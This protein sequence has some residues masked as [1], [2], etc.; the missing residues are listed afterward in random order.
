MKLKERL[1]GIVAAVATAALALSVAPV[2]AMAANLG[3]GT[4]TVKGLDED[5]TKVELYK[6]ATIT[7]TNDDN[8]LEV[9][10]VDGYDFDIEEYEADPEGV[11]NQI[12]AAVTGE[13]DYSTP[14][15]WTLSGDQVVFE[16]VVPG[17]Y[18]VKISTYN[19][20]T[21]Y[22]PVIMKVA[23]VA[24]DETGEWGNVSGECEPKKDQSFVASSLKK[25]VKDANGDWQDDYTNTLSDAD[26]A[27][28]KIVAP[29]PEYVGLDSDD[30]VTF[31]LTDVL[32]D[33]LTLTG[34]PAQ[35]KKLSSI[36]GSVTENQNFGDLTTENNTVSFTMDAVDLLAAYDTGAKYV[37]IT[38]KADIADGFVGEITNEVSMSWYQHVWDKRPVKTTDDA[39]VILYQASVTKKAA[40]GDDAGHTLNGAEYRLEKQDAEDVWVTVEEKVTSQD[41]VAT[42]NGLAAG[43]YRWVET[44]APAGYQ[45]NNYGDNGGLIFTIDNDANESGYKVASDF[46][47]YKE[48]FISGLPETGGTGTVALTVVGMGLMAG[49]AFLVMRSRKEN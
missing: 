29:I 38:F 30:Q 41:A 28:F 23:P 49:A 1:R 15:D 21:V 16:E 40:D 11:A 12:A 3:T 10:P 33:G 42:V 6:V 32:P 20:D 37:E 8:V 5:V 25:Y 19:A 22:Q 13:A 7:D 44:K 43:T 14:D 39:S 48:T 35:A 2:T 4:A 47:D 31:R 9:A 34:E 26:T 18:Y 46:V 17:L 24:N 36:D 27:E 45:I